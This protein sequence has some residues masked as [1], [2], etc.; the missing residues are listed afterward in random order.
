MG[1]NGKESGNYYLGVLRLGFRVL[2]FG[3]L[4]FQLFRAQRFPAGPK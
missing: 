1:G 2:A 4:G 3:V